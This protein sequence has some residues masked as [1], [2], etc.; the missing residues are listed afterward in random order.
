MEKKMF[1]EA[2]AEILCSGRA[3][4]ENFPNPAAGV[5]ILRRSCYCK[6]TKKKP[7]KPSGTMKI[8]CGTGSMIYKSVGKQNNATQNRTEKQSDTFRHFFR[9]EWFLP[10]PY[11]KKGKTRKCTKNVAMP[12]SK[13]EF[14]WNVRFHPWSGSFLPS[15]G[16]SRHIRWFTPLTRTAK[17]AVA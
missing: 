17:P 14:L 8:R 2:E 4:E 10:A 9:V 6:G 12:C 5:A 3:R 1:P 7:C 13:E 11:N 15:P 16:C